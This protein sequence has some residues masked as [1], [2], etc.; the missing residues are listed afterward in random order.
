MMRGIIVVCI[1]LFT[2]FGSNAQNDKSYIKQTIKDFVKTLPAEVASNMF[3]VNRYCNG[4]VKMFMMADG[5]RCVTNGDYME[6]YL[7][8]KEASGI[9]IKKFDNCGAYQA[10]PM[11]DP[12][13]FTF[14]TT[15][16]STIG[17]EQIKPYKTPEENTQPLARTKVYRC[18]RTFIYYS[19][20]GVKP[21][22]FSQY[23]LSNDSLQPNVNYEFNHNLNT[24]KLDLMLDPIIVKLEENKTFK[25]I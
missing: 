16:N 11:D 24:V 15:H 17:L 10:V 3:S 22:V 2:G 19:P 25:R 20:E 12:S 23:D 7:I 6:V 1:I 5:S 4:S 13:A 18:H 8:Y 21:V 9:M 14:Y